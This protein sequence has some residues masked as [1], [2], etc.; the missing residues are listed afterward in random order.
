PG[1][2]RLGRL[3]FLRGFRLKSE[4]SRFGGLSGLVVSPDG[5]MIYAVSDAGY[6]LS[7]R[8]RHDSQARLTGLDQWTMASLLTPEGT[9]VSI[10]QRDAEAL[11]LDRDGSLLVAFEQIHRVW[12][13]PP[14]PPGFTASAAPLPGPPEIE[15]APPNQGME[16]LTVLPDGRLLAIT[17]EY[18]NADGSVKAWLLEKDRFVP[19]SYIVSDGF[20][21]T[22]V[23]ALP[24]GDLLVLERGYGFFSGVTGRIQWISRDALHPGAVLRGEEVASFYPPLL[25]DNFE[26]IA[27][28]Q[29]SNGETLVYIVSDDNYNFFQ[30]TYLLQFRLERDARK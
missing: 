8:M 11:A 30:R 17:E 10:R 1:E 12:R 3:T 23:A 18:K 21:P 27:V 13:Y 20:L 16:G 19:L 28:H 2:T 14:P 26:G 25:V 22:D 4:D 29:D 24:D 9:S 7:T 5:S 6:W 15:N